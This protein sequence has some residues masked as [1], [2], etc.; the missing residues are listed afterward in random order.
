MNIHK[1]PLA[2]RGDLYLKTGIFGQRIYTFVY[3][4][5]FSHF[6]CAKM[7]ENASGVRV[8]KDIFVRT[9][10]ESILVVS[11]IVTIHEMELDAKFAYDG[12]RHDFWEMVYVD[13]GEV[14]IRRNEEEIFLRQGDLVFHEPNEFHGIRA[15][16]S[17]P[18]IFILSFESASPMMREFAG[19]VGAL[20]KS[21]RAYIASILDEAKKTYGIVINNYALVRLE[22]RPDAP[23]GGEQLI[24]TY[25][26]QLLIMLRRYEKKKRARA[27]VPSRAA[28]EKHIVT[29]L[30]RYI[31]D[32]LEKRMNLS[33]ICKVFGYS[34][35][36]LCGLFRE[37][38]G[39]TILHYVS[40]A[41][42]CRAKELIREGE[43]NFA[44]ISDS[45]AFDNPQ[46][47]TR[48]F[49]R[50]AGMSPSEFRRTLRRT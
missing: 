7:K 32:N 20:D 30:R 12:E 37:E 13:K 45:L 50:I 10:P 24:K 18:N 11:K 16:R 27:V 26:E 49:R 36:Y 8:E 40:V 46:Y 41:K 29:L 1:D 2:L 14:A 4:R 43:M 48:V 21:L 34:K 31:E 38:T 39:D 17:N 42:I 22:K 19:Y 25:L 35:T 47:F 33:D 23:L 5:L 28:A 3:I 15:Y 9:E 44:E 6:V